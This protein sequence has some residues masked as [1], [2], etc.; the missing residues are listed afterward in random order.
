MKSHD[1]PRTYFTPDEQETI[2]RSIGA[3]EARGRGE[4]RVHLGRESADAQKAAHAIF[5]KLG[6]ERTAHRAG[7]LIYVSLAKR[8][9]V[10]LGD[11][12]IDTATSDSFWSELVAEVAEGFRRDE[13]ASGLRRVI[14]RLGDAFADAFPFEAGAA[15]DRRLPDDLSY[16]DPPE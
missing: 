4:I 5:H 15:P 13:A 8:E 7:V 1:D 14:E 3:A 9:V 16:D 2:V 12:G 11:S 10:I 6:M